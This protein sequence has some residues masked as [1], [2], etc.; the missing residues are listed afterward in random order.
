MKRDRDLKLWLTGLFLIWAA[1]FYPTIASTVEIWIRSET[2]NHCFIILPVCVYVIYQRWSLLSAVEVKPNWLLVVPLI[3]AL[4]L[5][6]FGVLAQLLVIEQGA[7]FLI[8]PIAIWMVLGNQ[9][10]KQL[11]FP[12]LF[13]MFSVPFGEFLVPQ[14]QNLTADI[15]VW[16]I[17]LTGIPVYREGLYIS[18]PGGLFEV[19]VACSGIRYLIASVSLGLLYAYL[20]YSSVKKRVAFVI[21]AF[22]MPLVANGIR[23]FGI[24]MI[25]YHSEMKYATGVDHLIY[26]WLFFGVIILLMF[27]IGNIWAD[28]PEKFEQHSSTVRNIAIGQTGLSAMAFVLLVGGSLLYQQ[29]MSTLPAPPVPQ[30]AKLFP[31]QPHAQQPSWLPRF[32]NPSATYSGRSGQKDIFVAFYAQNIQGSELVNTTN[33]EYNHDD[34]TFDQAWVEN[35]FRVVSI[36]NSSGVKRYVAYSYMLPGISTPKKLKIKLKQAVDAFLGNSQEGAFIA[37]S[38]VEN[39]AKNSRLHLNQTMQSY[40]DQGYNGLFLHD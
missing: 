15:S 34:W 3:G 40:L 8:L 30:L 13:W 33:L 7:A 18:V 19:A 39:E 2:F 4:L 10:A 1:L 35:G 22:I 20:S 23:A 14:L 27:S 25:A 31:S 11:W 9:V 26:G 24:I 6:L 37:I 32:T 38:V 17:K 16:L 36:V 28:P 21:F 12:F 29:K 5:W